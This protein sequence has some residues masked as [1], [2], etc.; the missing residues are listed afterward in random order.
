VRRTR[1]KRLLPETTAGSADVSGHGV[2]GFAQRGTVGRE[3]A[4]V[5]SQH[6]YL[7]EAHAHVVEVVRCK[8]DFGKG[9]GRGPVIHNIHLVGN[10]AGNSVSNDAQRESLWL[11]SYSQMMRPSASIAA[12]MRIHSDTRSFSRWTIKR[13]Y[14]RRPTMA[15]AAMRRIHSEICYA[16]VS[17]N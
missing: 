2:H 8:A 15:Y 14:R 11:L 12:T 13:V 7:G 9:D 16:D 6:A 1:C 10:G 4:P 3:N 5:E 17:S